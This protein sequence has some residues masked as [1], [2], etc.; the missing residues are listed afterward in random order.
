MSEDRMNC[1]KHKQDIG[2]QNPG[3]HDATAG[4]ELGLFFFYLTSGSP[5]TPEGLVRQFEGHKVQKMGTKH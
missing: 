3:R 5:P 2:N 1:L 4:L